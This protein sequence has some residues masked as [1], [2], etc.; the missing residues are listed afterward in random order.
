MASQNHLLR[1]PIEKIHP[2]KTCLPKFQEVN[3]LQCMKSRL[4]HLKY[5]SFVMLNDNNS[6]F[7]RNLLKLSAVSLSVFKIRSRVV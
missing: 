4:I 3:L 2:P 6:S 5:V 7:S 1:I